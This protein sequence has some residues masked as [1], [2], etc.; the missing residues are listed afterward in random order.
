VS[1]S[2]KEKASGSRWL[3]IGGLAAVVVLAVIVI[4]YVVL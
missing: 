2:G 1:E 4:A 3:V